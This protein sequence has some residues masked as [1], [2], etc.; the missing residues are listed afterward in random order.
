M[1][2]ELDRRR[3]LA[4]S[5]LLGT[6][7]SIFPMMLGGCGG[8]EASAQSSTS[9]GA[10]PVP[11]PVPVA[12]G[13]TTTQWRP[14]RIGAG[15]FVTGIDI[16][17]DG[18][19]VIKCDTYGG[20]IWDSGIS[21]WKPLLTTTSLPAGEW[22]HETL[23]EMGVTEVVIAP[24]DSNRIYIFFNGL[25]FKSVNKGV[26]F[27]KTT[28]P[29][30]TAT[31]ND[32][33]KTIG[34]KIAVDPVNPEV[35][36]VGTP[37]N[38]LQVTTN[39]GATWTTHPGI[40]KSKTLA[41]IIIA[42][43][44]SSGVTA[45]KTNGVYVSSDG[46]G[47]YRST[48]AGANFAITSTGPTTHRRMTCDQTGVLWLTETG[49]NRNLW[50]Y[51]AGIWARIPLAGDDLHTIAVDPK[52]PKHV[53]V[54]GSG[55]GI[56]QSFDGGVI[57]TGFYYPTYPAGSGRRVADDIPWL[58]WTNESFLSC[59]EMIFDPTA[60]NKLYFA[61]GIGV[62]YTT[63][64]L[65]PQWFAGFD[66]ISQSKGIE[67]LV[68]N[69][70]VVPAGGGVPLYFAWDRPVFQIKNP[71]VFPTEHGPNREKTI[72][73]GWGGDYALDDS[74][75]AVGLMNW[76]GFETSGYSTD[77]G[78]NWTKF[79]S[80]PPE[81]VAGK[82]GGSMA[83]STKDNIVWVP[84]N[85]GNPYYTK[86]RGA[87]WKQIAIAGVSTTNELGWGWAYYLN[88]Q[89]VAADKVTAGTFYMYNYLQASVGV[90]RST[91]GGTDWTRVYNREIATGSSFN[92]SLAAVPGKAGHLFFTSGNQSG[93]NP[94]QTS[95]M[96]S[97]DGGATWTAVANAL[98]VY[99]FGF[100]KAAPSSDYPAIYIAG[101]IQNQWG[102]YRSD[103]NATTWIKIGDYPLGNFD[104]IKTLSGDMNIYGRVYVGFTGS[105]AV[106]ADLKTA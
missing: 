53:V 63:L 24:S 15:G 94:A 2:N 21:E 28:F 67:Q 66:W 61:E 60:T 48:D 81:I 26:S 76:W 50:R 57:W 95:F 82:I 97:T 51:A 104:T 10:A 65:P 33:A 87:T 46:Y 16:A 9:A 75:F 77:G 11:A 47:V 17:P 64:P 70:I 83:V 68:S 8:A 27:T 55:G 91:N 78:A 34:R 93:S 72:V 43:D 31:S 89:I 62:W 4:R 44:P 18:T 41:G 22:G 3:F 13:V 36:Y 25:I 23:Y 59:G 56:S 38:G 73:M 71:D 84:S 29:K 49:T 7:V 85:N 19:K 52:D 14:L 103:D 39:G 100:G 99:A 45:G 92:A 35:V 96:R 98:E 86:D 40:P 32:D 12:P 6:S 102:L 88:R 80:Y 30:S 42:F 106:V 5:T 58:A 74:S 90:Y 79:A 37:D 54:G 101:Y 1:H 20:Y 69:R 105:G